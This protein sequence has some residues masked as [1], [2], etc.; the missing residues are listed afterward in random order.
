LLGTYVQIENEKDD[1]FRVSTA[2]PD[3]W[4]KKDDLSDDMFFKVFFLDVGQGDGILIE[5]GGLNDDKRLK[6]LIDAGLKDNMLN[7]L[8]K[9]QY[10]YVKKEEKVHFDYV[11]ISH[12]DADHF[13]GLIKIIENPRFTFG[14]VY[15]PGI[16]KFASNQQAYNTILGDTVKIDNTQVLKT[17]FS[18]LSDITP[19]SELNQGISALV[20]AIKNAKAE[21]RL[22]SVSK[23][24]AGTIP[25]N[26]RIEGNDLKV[27]VLAP[28]TDN[29]DGEE[30]C[31]YFGDE[32]KTIN[33]HSL[34]LKFTYGNRTFLF[35]GDLNADAE[36]YISK[37]Y[38][39]DNPFEVDVAKACH[40]GSSDFTTDFMAL[41]NP[42]ATVISSGDNEAYAHPRA[43]AIGCAGK[44]ARGI[45]PLVFS[46]ELARSVDLRT[47]R[48]LYGLINLRCDGTDIF[49][50]QMK[51]KHTGGNVWDSYKI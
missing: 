20:E 17:I 46:T 37:K 31:V 25:L 34:V 51:E 15:H 10:S 33:G 16:V 21:R 48:I 13:T 44:Y 23:I 39:P 49:I 12:F 1:F 36:N 29:I 11:F 7:Y 30:T 26:L 38:T 28:F 18:D 50:S 4:M 35:G 9:W 6:I 43:D 27:E 40:H 32:G 8:T 19:K 3:G 14:E 22:K 24:K 41:V 47:K 2:G 5:V 42:F 45:R